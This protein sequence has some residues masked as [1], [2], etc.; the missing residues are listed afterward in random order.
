MVRNNSHNGERMTEEGRKE[1]SKEKEVEGM[2]EANEQN[3]IMLKK[4]GDPRN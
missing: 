1:G 4:K 2:K 3:Q